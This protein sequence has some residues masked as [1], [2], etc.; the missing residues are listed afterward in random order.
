MFSIVFVSS[1]EKVEKKL[2]FREEKF[3]SKCKLAKKSLLSLIEISDCLIETSEL[4]SIL[5]EDFSI[6]NVDL[7]DKEC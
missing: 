3:F 7:F 1:S 5:P 2:F 4:A 6:R